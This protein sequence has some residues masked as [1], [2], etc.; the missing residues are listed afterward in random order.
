MPQNV[1]NV[2]KG[3]NHYPRSFFEKKS[4]FLMRNSLNLGPKLRKK[5]KKFNFGTSCNFVKFFL[6]LLASSCYMST[7]FAN[8]CELKGSK[9]SK[10]KESVRWCSFLERK[11][12]C[13]T[14]IKIQNNT[15]E[16]E[17]KSIESLNVCQCSL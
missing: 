4:N 2:Q 12:L 9:Q 5:F 1:G 17:S 7:V 6:H 11:I 8:F 13:F 14:S 16:S 15:N 10:A 3:K